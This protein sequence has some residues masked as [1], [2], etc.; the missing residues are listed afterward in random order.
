M[1]EKRNY[2]LGKGEN[3]ARNEVVKLGFGEGRDPYSFGEQKVHLAPQVRAAS[4]RLDALPRSA[5][6]HDEGVAILTLHPKYLSKSAYP[7]ELLRAVGLRA[8][9]S[10]GITITPRKTHLQKA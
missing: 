8:V 9:G 2:L 7:T 5:C 1:A 4:V 10:K 3:L 6:P